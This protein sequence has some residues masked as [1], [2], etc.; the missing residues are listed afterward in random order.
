MVKR[1][2]EQDFILLLASSIIILAL[3]MNVIPL[4]S[5]KQATLFKQTIN[6]FVSYEIKENKMPV[7][8]AGVLR[9]AF[10]AK[11]IYAVD[12]DSGK[13]LIARNTNEPVLPAST[14]KIATALVALEHY[15]LDTVLTVG[16]IDVEGQTMELVPGERLSID[17]LLYGLLVFSANDA[18][19]VLAGNYPGGRDNFVAEM[20]R[21]AQRLGLKNTHFT[22][23]AGL[24]AYLHFST[25]KDLAILAAH[26]VTNPVFAEIVAT[27]KIDVTSIDGEVVHKLVNINQLVGNVPGVLGVKTGWTINA[28][29]SLV[30]LVERDGKRAVISVLGSNDRFG[31]TEKLIDW[32]FASYSWD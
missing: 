10:S 17:S 26:A 12:V 20:N 2:K 14:T 6:K 18:A 1:K 9:P 30:T 23:P 4:Q 8:K 19:E 13:I 28:G 11:A 3:I 5:I 22:N 32:I 16:E 15:N 27:P 25:A 31:E 29:E 24:D 7:L 21:L